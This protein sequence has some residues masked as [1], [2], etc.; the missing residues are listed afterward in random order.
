MESRLDGIWDWARAGR[1]AGFRVDR[2]SQQ[3]G[4][5]TRE[6]ERYFQARFDVSPKLWLDRLRIA[7]AQSHLTQGASIKEISARL[8]FEKPQDFA[9]AFKRINGC[10]PSRWRHLR[11]DAPLSRRKSAE[12]S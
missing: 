9:R 6:I 7:D 5:S 8:G 4:V 12:M 2:L 3:A 11:Q 10:T 1:K